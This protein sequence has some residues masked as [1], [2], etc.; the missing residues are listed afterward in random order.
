MVDPMA[1]YNVLQY[2]LREFKATDARVSDASQPLDCCTAFPDTSCQTEDQG[3][4]LN[5]TGV[6]DINRNKRVAR[7]AASADFLIPSKARDR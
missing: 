3:V 2:I 4:R 5:F 1:E 6:G 7:S